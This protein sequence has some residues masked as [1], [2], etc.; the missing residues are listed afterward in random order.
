MELGRQERA[1]NAR[2]G[3]YWV[4]MGSPPWVLSSGVTV[5]GEHMEGGRLRA[6]RSTGASDTV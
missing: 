1:W 3:V 5:I 6:G 2:Q 4:W